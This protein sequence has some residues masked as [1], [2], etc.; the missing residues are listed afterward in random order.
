MPSRMSCVHCQSLP[1]LEA[2]EVVPYTTSRRSARAPVARRLH[3]LEAAA[4]PAS[5][6]HRQRQLRAWIVTS[7]AS[8]AGTPIGQ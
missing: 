7:P 8:G 3:R 2:V 1:D 4:T 5:G 6:P